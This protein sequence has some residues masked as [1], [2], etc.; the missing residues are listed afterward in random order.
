M[1]LLVAVVKVVV[2]GKRKKEV[3]KK[4][5]VARKQTIQNLATI[6][7]IAAEIAV[8]RTVIARLLFPMAK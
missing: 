6:K 5:V 7:K 3:K 1:P 4:V 8:K 2:K